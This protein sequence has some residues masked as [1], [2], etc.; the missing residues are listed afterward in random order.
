MA[1]LNVVELM[2][3]IGVVVVLVAIMT[4]AVLWATK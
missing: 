3:P 1:I 4:I 2:G